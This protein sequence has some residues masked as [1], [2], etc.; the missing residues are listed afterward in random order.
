MGTI[1][2]TAAEMRDAAMAC[3]AY[4]FAREKEVA[5]GAN[6]AQ[7]EIL[8]ATQH[9]HAD[10]AERFDRAAAIAATSQPGAAKAPL[11]RE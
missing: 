5:D 2:M 9:R 6:P 8:L 3:R 10:L 7:R 4:A 11:R 1:R